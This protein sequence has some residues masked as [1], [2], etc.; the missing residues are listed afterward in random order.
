MSLNR[1]NKKDNIQIDFQMTVNFDIKDKIL[2]PETQKSKAARNQDT[3]KKKNYKK[4]SNVE[5]ANK[6]HH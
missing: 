6:V 3:E 1:I 5:N 2:V 4:A